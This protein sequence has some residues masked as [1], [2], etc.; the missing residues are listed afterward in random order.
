MKYE[1]E[2]LNELYTALCNT[3]MEMGS[4]SKSAT[5]PFYKSKYANFDSVVECSRP[6]LTK[7]GLCVIQRI[8]TE[9][10][11]SFLLTRLAHCSGQWIESRIEL[12]PVKQDP[13]ELAKYITYMRRYT[14][15]SICCITTEEDDDAENS[16][17]SI[18]DKPAIEVIS[19]F[20]VKSLKEKI[21]DERLS[22]F[23]KYFE[24]D[25]LQELPKK[26]FVEAITKLDKKK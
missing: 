22:A 23:L 21:S 15:S 24:I 8:L 4:A 6:Y 18:R 10:G 3:Q 5:N 20:Q 25:S 9:D 12:K 2:N 17:K 16:M 13:Q 14:Y 7:N 19:D 1:S 26:R 11:I